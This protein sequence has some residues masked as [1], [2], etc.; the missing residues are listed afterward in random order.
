[1]K[2]TKSQVY[3]FRYIY[4]YC[5]GSFA[6]SKKHSD[7]QN[8]LALEKQ[9]LLIR[10]KSDWLNSYGRIKFILTEKAEKFIKDTGGLQRGDMEKFIKEE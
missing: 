9:G 8:L 10:E 7:Y 3:L 6:A 4:G 5:Y 1:M 2:F